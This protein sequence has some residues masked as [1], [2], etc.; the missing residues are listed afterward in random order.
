MLICAASTFH[1]TP[2]LF[3]SIP[4]QQTDYNYVTREQMLKEIGEGQFIENAEFS[5]N[6]YGTSKKAVAV[7]KIFFKKEKKKI[8]C[9]YDYLFSL[10]PLSLSL[11]FIYLFIY[12]FI[13]SS[14]P[15]LT[16]KVQDARKIC[17]LD[18]E[19]KVK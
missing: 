3:F 13:Y 9:P 11:S 6:L 7:G 4:A 5:G 15:F 14:H 12:L 18:I 10:L 2:P 16:Q 19:Q 17:I 8:M 1:E